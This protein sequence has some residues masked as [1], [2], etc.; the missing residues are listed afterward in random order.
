MAKE[1][2]ENP[3]KTKAG[4]NVYVG[5]ERYDAILQHAIDISADIRVQVSPSQ[6]VQH[7][8][9]YYSATAQLNWLDTLN[10]ATPPAAVNQDSETTNTTNANVYLG[11]ER[12]DRIHQCAI[13]VSADIRVQVTPSQFVHH[14]VD[15]YSETARKNW[16][17]TVANARI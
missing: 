2:P 12:C 9:D 8:V 17:A 15:Y 10:T 7:L 13:D 5:Y 4:V 16:L 11:Q 14:L 3:N 1:T 6:F